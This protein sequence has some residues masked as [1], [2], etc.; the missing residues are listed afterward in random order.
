MTPAYLCFRN[1]K[2]D[3]V[4]LP[5]VTIPL[6]VLLLL[7]LPCSA[8]EAGDG[9]GDGDGRAKY[10]GHWHGADCCRMFLLDRLI[11][12]RSFELIENPVKAKQTAFST[13]SGTGT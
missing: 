5:C 2:T 13:T 4:R 8:I 12:A 6:Q 10:K 9:D 7:L 3:P 11:D 1:L